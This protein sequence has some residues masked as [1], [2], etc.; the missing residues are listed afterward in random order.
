MGIT[1]NF[2]MMHMQLNINDIKNLRL[3]IKSTMDMYSKINVLLTM[4]KSLQ[5]TSFKK[6]YILL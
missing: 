4:K 6:F 2:V 5:L 1:T 3:K